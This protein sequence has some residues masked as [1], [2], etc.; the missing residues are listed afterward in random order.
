MSGKFVMCVTG[1]LATYRF[2]IMKKVFPDI[3]KDYIIVFTNTFSLDL[4]KDYHKDFTFVNFDELRK[5][6]PFSLENEQF[7]EVKTEEEFYKNVYEFYYRDFSRPGKKVNLYSYDIHRFA[8]PWLAKNDILN[9]A[10]ID[11]DFILT[12]DRGIVEDYFKEIPDNTLYTTWFFGGDFNAKHIKHQFLKEEVQ[13]LFPDKVFDYSNLLNADGFIKGFKMGNKEDLIL[14]FDIWNKSMKKLF[15]N[16]HYLHEI[17][18]GRL[19]FDNFW[20]SPY[21]TGLFKNWGY[22]IRNTH[23]FRLSG[24]VGRHYTRA[25]DTL[26]Y[27]NRPGWEMYNFDYSDMSSIKNFIKNN[28]EQLVKYYGPFKVEVTDSHVYTSMWR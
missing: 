23:D 10:L 25:E 4:Y 11:N 16:N 14:F 24:L 6:Y 8:L 5:D 26:Y 12:N 21:I 7:M 28:K 18:G 22:S 1:P 2:D 15:A 17:T 19:M 20:L 13:P 9:F 3:I 27:Q